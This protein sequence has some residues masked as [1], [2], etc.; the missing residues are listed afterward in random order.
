MA[1]TGLTVHNGTG[2]TA[3]QLG[4]YDSGSWGY[5]QSGYVNN[6]TVAREFRIMNGA[7]YSMTLSNTGNVGIGTTSPSMELDVRNDGSSGI[8]EIGVRGGTNG[9]G[10]VQISGHG[11]TYGTDSFDLIQNSSGAFVQHRANLPLMF[12]TNNTERMRIDS[13]GHLIPGASNTYDL[14]SQANPWRDDACASC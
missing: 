12:A 9:A 3:V 2:G 6:A 10:A 8:A 5:I 13:N 7:N 1:S 4:T 11:T 14:G